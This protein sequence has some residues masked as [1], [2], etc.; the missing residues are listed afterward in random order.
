MLFIL[1]PSLSLPI[2]LPV[3]IRVHSLDKRCCRLHVKLD[4][5]AKDI[6]K[7]ACDKLSLQ[8]ESHKLCEA[9]SSGELVMFNPKRF[10]NFNGN[11]R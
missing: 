2:F 10:V 11:K 5:K 8:Y 9:K 7:E 6:L 4:T 1:S 3:N